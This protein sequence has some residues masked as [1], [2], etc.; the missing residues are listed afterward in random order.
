MR[1][2]Q[3]CYIQQCLVQ[4]ATRGR[5]RVALISVSVVMAAKIGVDIQQSL[6]ATHTAPQHCDSSHGGP[7]LAWPTAAAS[8]RW[9]CWPRCRLVIPA[10]NFAPFTNMCLPRYTTLDES[11][12]SQPA[13]PESTQLAHQ[14]YLTQ[15]S[16]ISG[17][18]PAP[19]CFAWGSVNVIGCHQRPS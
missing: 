13:T 16:N 15:L 17:V 19:S 18:S 11:S 9:Q 1:G 8:W 6:G 14:G 7:A 4:L 2:S 5:A 3:Q 12:A 10:I